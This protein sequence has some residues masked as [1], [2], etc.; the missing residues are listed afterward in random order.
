MFLVSGFNRAHDM[1]AG[2]TGAA[3]R[4]VVHD[5]FNAGAGRGDL[6]G[7]ISQS[8]RPIAD[9]S[10]EPAETTIGDQSAF[11]DPAQDVRVDVSSAEEEHDAFSCQLGKLT[12]QAGGEWRCGRALNDPLF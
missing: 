2:A 10:G 1:H 6:P 12:R 9:H 5:L 8:S 4:A 7:E 11:D 3:E